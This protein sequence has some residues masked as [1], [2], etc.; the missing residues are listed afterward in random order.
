MAQIARTGRDPFFT[1][2]A[3]GESL[4]PTY[5][6]LNQGGLDGCAIRLTR[7]F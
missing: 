6:S 4:I 2:S 7:Y 1:P 5:Q 3:D